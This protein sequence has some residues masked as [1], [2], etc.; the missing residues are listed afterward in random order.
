MCVA[1]GFRTAGWAGRAAADYR[2]AKAGRAVAA[3]L[4]ALA[5]ATASPPPAMAQSALADVPLAVGP[6]GRLIV[7]VETADG[8][9]L[10][11]ALHTA[12]PS[13]MVSATA[14]GADPGGLELRLAG[15]DVILTDVQVI[16]DEALGVGGHGV[17][18]FVL[19]SALGDVDV[20]IDAPAG[21]LLLKPIGRAVDWP[22]TTLS[23]PATLR[24][25]HG[26]ALRLEVEV[27][28][29]SFGATLD[30]ATPRT[31]VT[32]GVADGAGVRDGAPATLTFGGV[33]RRLTL[34]VGQTPVL[35]RWDPEAAGFVAFGADL[36]TDCALSIS[37]V[38]QE[39]RTCV[40]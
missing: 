18:G 37:Y 14:A 3:V 12:I 26:V 20:L 33:D 31:T 35:G 24:V 25:Y 5:G 19:L 1:R 34:A 30:L 28:G 7:P 22:G 32:A 17:D 6:E 11:F 4:V 15:T 9:T 10:R 39:L 21:R 16:P 27:E 36:A 29:R 40:R 13:A 8:R 2:G 38:H 23:A